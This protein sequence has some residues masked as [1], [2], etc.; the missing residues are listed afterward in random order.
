VTAEK[1]ESLRS[2]VSTFFTILDDGRWVPS[3]VFFSMV[4]G[5]PGS[6]S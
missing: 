1:L 4:D 5:N 6:A 2:E 3:P